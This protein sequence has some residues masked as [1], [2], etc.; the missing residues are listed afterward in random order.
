[1]AAFPLVFALRYGVDSVS[2]V[3]TDEMV[4]ACGNV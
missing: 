2:M 1:M 4:E 3:I